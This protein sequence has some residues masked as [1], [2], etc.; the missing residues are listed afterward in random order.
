MLLA[1]VAQRGAAAVKY[2]DKGLG[3]PSLCGTKACPY[4]RREMFSK[5]ARNY[6]VAMQSLCL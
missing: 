3:L 4:K 6:D 2:G 5:Q 1:W